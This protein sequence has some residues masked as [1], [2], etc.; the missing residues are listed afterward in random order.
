MN[1]LGSAAAAGLINSSMMVL[2]PLFFSSP[3]QLR[4][5]FFSCIRYH[6]SKYEQAQQHISD[7][8]KLYLQPVETL[9]AQST[10]RTATRMVIFGVYKLSRSNSHNAWGSPIRSELMALRAGALLHDIGKIAIP[11]YILNK[12]TALTDSEYSKMKLH[13]VVGGNMLKNIEFPTPSCRWC[14]FIMSDGMGTAIQMDYAAEEIPIG[15]RI[16][17]LRIAMML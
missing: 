8:N 5:F 3:Y 2:T 4:S 14:D 16:L 12:P 13:P 11:E 17:A 9:A 7:L 10:R 15:A 1:S 6:I